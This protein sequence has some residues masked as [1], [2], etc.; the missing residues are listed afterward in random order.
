MRWGK[1]RIKG[2]GKG[3]YGLL[4]RGNEDECT[5]VTPLAGYI[6]LDPWFTKT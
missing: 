6:R 2:A 1:M 3:N 4:A 5:D